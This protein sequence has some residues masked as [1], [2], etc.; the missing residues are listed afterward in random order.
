MAVDETIL[1]TVKRMFRSGLSEEA[2][3]SALD[4]LGLS[5]AEQ[6]ELIQ[7]V[8]GKPAPKPT[9]APAAEP[10]EAEEEVP[11]VF[12]EEEEERIAEKTADK[13]KAHLEEKEAVDALRETT[14][15]V[16]LDEQSTKLDEIREDLRKPVETV[17]GR[18]KAIELQIKTLRAENKAIQS[19]LKKIL[20]TDRDV[21]LR[22]KK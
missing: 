6:D 10:E 5:K 8:K 15:Q 20:E 22:L 12:A 18:L 13:V 19:L 17:E 3:R 2:V 14:A 9:P 1:R 7:A 21:L 11:S 4:D 16:A